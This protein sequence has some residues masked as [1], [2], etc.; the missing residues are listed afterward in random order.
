MKVD[1]VFLKR[2]KRKLNSI[3]HKP[4]KEIKAKAAIENIYRKKEEDEIIIILTG[5][6]GDSVY[7]LAFTDELRKK[8]PEKKIVVYGY[9]KWKE[10]YNSYSSI[11]EV[12][13]IDSSELM[14]LGDIRAIYGSNRASEKGR[15]IGIINGNAFYYKKCYQATNP[16]IIYQ[17]R[18]YIY[19]VGENANI[20]YHGIKKGEFPFSDVL[21][22]KLD[23]TK[24]VVLNPFSGSSFEA[25]FDLYE[26]IAIVLKEYG[27]NPVTNVVGNQK[28]IKGTRP[29]QCTIYQLYDLCCRIPLIVSIRSGIL[30]FVAPSNVNMFV[31]YENCSERLKKMYHLTNWK[32]DGKIEELY[33]SNTKKE[34]E[35]ILS[36]LE[37]FVKSI[38]SHYME[39]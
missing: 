20:T 9:T 26:A 19:D 33:P 17:L 21:P 15:K 3:L 28:C 36:A 27:Y 1:K 25:N 34:K 4:F 37:G 38:S 6:I 22:D 23:Y 5:A 24:T 12:K 39:G 18:T 8:A 14:E 7:A 31:I 32:C 11:D 10:L 13:Y 29:I 30:D 16:D 35:E 2:I